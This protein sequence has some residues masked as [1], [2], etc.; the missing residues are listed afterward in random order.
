M[1]GTYTLASLGV[2]GVNEHYDGWQYTT[3]PKCS[4]TRKPGS[5]G[6]TCLSVHP[7]KGFG[8]CHNCGQTFTLRRGWDG[9]PHYRRVKE[10]IEP[11]FEPDKKVAIPDTVQRYFK[12]RGI[13]I[14]T[15]TE[16][17]VSYRDSIYFPQYEQGQ[18]FKPAI[19]FPFFRDGNVINVK[20]RDAKEKNFRLEAGA[21]RSFYGW[22][23]CFDVDENGTRT[24]SK[25]CVI[26]EGEIDVLSFRE[27][28]IKYV[29][30]V[31]DGA[32]SPQA[33]NWSSKFDFLDTADE[34]LKG[35]D[36]VFLAVDADEPGRLLEQELGRRIGIHKCFKLEWPEDIKDAN[37]FL[38]VLG[39]KELASY[40]KEESRPFPVAGIFYVRDVADRVWTR[41]NGPTKRGTS[42]GYKSLDEHFRLDAGQLII[43]TGI[44]GHGKSALW[45][46]IMVNTAK[47]HEDTNYDGWKWAVCSPENA[48]TEKHV[49]KL[50][51]IY[52]GLPFYQGPTPRLTPPE[53][54]QALDWL[55]ERFFWVMPE[56]VDDFTL[57]GVLERFDFLVRK[58]GVRGVQMDPWNEIEHDIPKSITE[59]QYISRALTK[60]RKFA[61][62]RAVALSL[63][64]HPTKLQ[65]DVKR[66]AYPVPTLYDISGAAH[67]RNKADAGLVQ[68]RNGRDPEAP[69]KTFIQKIREEGVL[70][71]LGRIEMRFDKLTGRFIDIPQMYVPPVT[72]EQKKAAREEE[73]AF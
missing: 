48:P 47:D 17:K 28:G 66:N 69:S 10:F 54:Q 40:F 68:W 35:F 24:Q 67:W 23:N 58:F 11:E 1:Q 52:G 31:P 34:F 20:Y 9:D 38:K 13:G 7:A 49:I 18:N 45:D 44:P 12:K 41:Y 63:I 61:R 6:K 42:T 21:E 32:P 53:L 2:T 19:C 8:R 33:K 29:M 72:A 39:P 3:C 27:A 51:S 30:S 64:A 73:G 57:D 15:L 65:K 14:K 16:A 4:D 56:G 36:E 59:T 26:V 55:S 5:R 43:T 50:A 46:N 60:L 70:G 22:D 25:W 71:K 62:D 37:D